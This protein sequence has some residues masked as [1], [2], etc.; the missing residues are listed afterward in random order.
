VL[1][2]NSARVFNLTLHGVGDPSRPLEAGEEK[3]WLSIATLE[4]LL[5]EV[6]TRRNLRIT[7]DDGNS[8][9]AQILLWELGRRR[10]TAAF[11]VVAGRLNQDA[12]LSTEDVEAI[13]R[14]G[15]ALGSHGMRHRP[16]RGL[17]PQALEDELSKAREVL[18]SIGGKPITELSCPFGSYD[19]RVLSR[20]RELRY[21]HVYTSDGGPADPRAWLQPRTTISELGQPSVGDIKERSR[22][23]VLVGRAKQT[24]KRWR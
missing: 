23:G 22:R 20:A 13:L 3:V 14:A 2:P 7:V 10:L 24:V 5:D 19:R 18:E 15:H 12:F 6:R 8:S 11:F 9:D 4:K 21:E 1:A 17:D 16:L